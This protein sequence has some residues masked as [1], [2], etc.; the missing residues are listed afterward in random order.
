M[1]LS[2]FDPSQE[3]TLQVDASTKGLGAAILQ[4]GRPIAFASKALTDVEARYANIERELLSVVYGCER[5]HTYL[6]GQSFTVE[7]DN[8][9]LESIHLKHLMSAPPRLQKMLLRL[10]P[11]DIRIKYIPGKEMKVADVL[12]RI[13]PCEKHAVPDMEVQIHEVCP[14]FSNDILDR[15]RKETAQDMELNTL[16]DIVYSGWPVKQNELPS[17]IQP[18]WS[19]R[20]EMAIEAGILFKGSRL[21]IPKAMQSEIMKKL[22]AAHQGAEKTKLRARSCVFWRNLNND[23]D[24]ITK[25]CG[26][27][28]KY[29]SNQTKEPLVQ[30]EVPPRPWHTI[31]TDLFF[32]NGDEYLLVSDYYSKYSFVRKIPKSQSTSQTVVNLMKEIFGEHGIPM[33]VRSDNGPH[34]SRQA[35]KQFAIDYGFTHN[36]SSPHYPRSNGFVE[37]Q[38]K[39]VKKTIQKAQ[40]TKSDVNIAL[41]SL[42][43]TPVSAKIPSPAEM[44]YKRTI[45]DNLPRRFSKEITELVDRQKS[46]K[47]Y[48]DQH[49]KSLPPLVQGQSVRIQNPQNRQ[50]EQATVENPMPDDKPRSYRINTQTGHQLRR[51]RVQIRESATQHPIAPNLKVHIPSS[52]SSSRHT[53]N[54]SPTSTSPGTTAGTAE[55]TSSKTQ[56]Y[57]TRSGR[58]VKPPELYSKK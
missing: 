40:E 9:P 34:Y 6:Y 50:W 52:S 30:T 48:H 8:K 16:K 57:T 15:I 53:P 54:L 10:Q 38:V 51:N 33:T 11:Y 41:L 20:D 44:L 19:Y 32:L 28:Q 7:T 12:S 14:Q 25:S 3:V 55:A 31:G 37:N 24:N 23:I 35:F 56:P 49:I 26:I 1:I 43:A 27:C 45:Q 2:Y 58:S 39:I 42:R 46:Q 17:I 36:T 18:Y 13:S 4:N 21:I 5:F 29:M 22:H 47:Y